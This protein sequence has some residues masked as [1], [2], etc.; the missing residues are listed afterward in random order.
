MRGITFVRLFVVAA[1]L[2]TMAGCKK[3]YSTENSDANIAATDR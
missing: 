3:K 2:V 1:V